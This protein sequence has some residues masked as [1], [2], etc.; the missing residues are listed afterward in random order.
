[1]I[2]IHSHIVWGLDDGPASAEESIAMLDSA[3]ASGTTDI[4]ATP[5]SSPQYA[6]QSDLLQQ[7]IAEL[8]D[9]TDHRPEIHRGCEFHL[10]FDN[11]EDLLRLP[12]R[13]TINGKQYLLVEFASAQIG[14]H[15][16]KVLERLLQAGITPIVSHPERNAVLRRSLDRVEGWVE[17]G[18]LMQVT[19]L[20]I[21]GGF[22][23]SA[24]SASTRLLERGLVH[25]VASDAHDVAYRPPGLD[26]AYA[27]V[28][29]RYGADAAEILFRDNPR[30]IIQGDRLPGGRQVVCGSAP[31]WQV[32]KVS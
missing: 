30:A 25:V 16:D 13:Y 11:L 2:D 5:H 1:V 14:K 6:Y 19:A 10:S 28:Q 27:V 18:C 21:T 3:R 9:R 8:A 7:R 32:W 4:V 31:W 29:A 20:S 15:G 22:G 12:E 17:L 23:H 24:R 26:A